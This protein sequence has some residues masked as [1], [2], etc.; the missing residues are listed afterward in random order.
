[1]YKFAQALWSQG[2]ATFFFQV[3]LGHVVS[4]SVSEV[5][6]ADTHVVPIPLILQRNVFRCAIIFVEVAAVPTETF[7]QH[8]DVKEIFV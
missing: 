2:T 8:T 6:A 5:V 1:M 7:T 4:A 3:F